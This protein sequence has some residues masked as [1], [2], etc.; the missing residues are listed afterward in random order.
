MLVMVRMAAAF[1][2]THSADQGAQI[3]H[4]SQESLVEAGS[5]GDNPADRRA[6]NGAVEVEPD[7]LTKLIDRF[8]GQASIGAGDAGLA[9]GV[10]F[11]D[12]SL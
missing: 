5:A 6:K 12:T 1:R 9:A 8:L 11:L 3:D 2:G 10:T 4:L 7:T